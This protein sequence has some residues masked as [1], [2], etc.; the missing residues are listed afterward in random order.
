MFLIFQGAQQAPGKDLVRSIF[1]FLFNAAIFS[2]KSMTQTV[3]AKGWVGAG[4]G[5]NWPRGKSNNFFET[6]IRNS[7]EKR[8]SL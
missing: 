4:V 2:M 6:A 5:V 3:F 8:M 7:S 1:I